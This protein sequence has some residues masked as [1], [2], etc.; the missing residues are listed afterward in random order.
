MGDQI[1][2]AS[3]TLRSLALTAKCTPAC[4][5][6]ESKLLLAPALACMGWLRRLAGPRRRRAGAM[7]AGLLL[8][9][10]AFVGGPARAQGVITGTAI[11]G[12]EYDAQVGNQGNPATGLHV[13]LNA[14]GT[15]VVGPMNGSSGGNTTQGS[16]TIALGTAPTLTALPTITASASGF[17]SASSLDG[18]WTLFAPS[19][20]YNFA[21]IGPSPATVPVL[22]AGSTSGTLTVT[23]DPNRLYGHV[24]S[25][26]RITS[27]YIAN[28]FAAVGGQTGTAPDYY[29]S[30]ASM[31]NLGW[32]YQAFAPVPYQTYASTWEWGATLTAGQVGTITM[33]S[34]TQGGTTGQLR[35]LAVLT[36][37][38]A[39]SMMDPHIFIDPTWLAAHPGYSIEVD[40]SVGN[41][42]AVSPVPEPATGGLLL[43][44]L[45]AVAVGVGR[46]RLGTA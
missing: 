28:S 15:Y 17:D 46:R 40:A 21:V 20:S 26:I 23:G 19:L 34:S 11:V 29:A 13:A 36:G 30:N 12:G 9:A 10:L 18:A 6:F 2:R 7:I 31:V 35:G 14:A 27:D 3:C 33:T 44:G 32:G 45:V 42:L 37:S 1:S 5:V 22:F 38:T 39:T 41:G 43:A 25:R 16:M 4:A 8:S 24:G